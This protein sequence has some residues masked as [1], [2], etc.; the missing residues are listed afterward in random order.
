M[1]HFGVSPTI[2]PYLLP[3][4]IARL[5]ADMPGLRLHIRE[6]IPDELA[7]HLASGAIDLLIA[8]LP[9]SGGGMHVELLV[10][11]PMHIVASVDHPLAA[12]RQLKKSELENLGV[13]SLDPRH[14]LYRQV[15][16][17]CADL[18]MFLLRDY[19]GTSLDSL[20]QMSASGL[21]LAILPEFYLRSEVGG[22]AGVK[23]LSI[24]DYPISR[25]IAL[26]WRQ[27]APFDDAC[28]AIADRIRTEAQAIL[29]TPS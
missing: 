5:H 2:G 11:E 20:H 9:L 14:H 25:Q 18:K 12:R 3:K 24:K 1:L 16:D 22:R 13:L 21:G 17:V 26:L 27:G 10:V 19:E 15:A 4:I 29:A 7:L 28:K 8:P 23:T 6:G